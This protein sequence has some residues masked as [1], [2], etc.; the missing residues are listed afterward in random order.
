MPRRSSRLNNRADRE[1]V[2]AS[3]LTSQLGDTIEVASPCL[4]VNDDLGA[5]KQELEAEGVD[6]TCWWRRALDDRPARAW[7]SDST[8]KSAVLRLPKDWPTFALELDAIAA[9]LEPGAHLYLYGA[10]DEGIKTAQ[11]RIT[12]HGFEE[13]ETLYIK[14]RSRVVCATRS[15]SAEPQD[16][17]EAFASRE[18][19]ELP[20]RDS[21]IEVELVAYPGVFARG[22]LDDG[23]RILL[24]ALDKVK[25]RTKVLDFACGTGIVGRW[26]RER[27]PDCRVTLLEVDAIAL[28]AA[29]QNVPGAI[30]L[31]GDGW[32][33]LTGSGNPGVSGSRYDA[34]L[35]NPPI[36]RGRDEDMRVA[37]ELVR[38]APQFLTVGGLLVVVVQRTV[39]LGKV[40]E[41]TF[42]NPRLLAESNAFQVWCG[43]QR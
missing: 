38:R 34:I 21:S 19:L 17:L 10:N 7:P 40:F 32:S 15:A 8:F 36:H 3:V 33:A 1:P 9:R 42:R 13:P 29:K 31:L 23:T 25:P 20:L 24:E 26:A 14:H 37:V 2:I 27:W 39:G 16:D 12:S 18:T 6:V 11:K 43:S 30:D 28:H 4:L 41:E 22:K 35:S 5:V